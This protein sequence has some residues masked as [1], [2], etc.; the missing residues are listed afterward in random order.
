[1]LI[2][3][4]IIFLLI[5]WISAD[6]REKTQYVRLLDIFLYGPIMVY[7]SL[8]NSNNL[9]YL[10]RV[11]LLIIGSTTITYNAKNYLYN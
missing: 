3:L 5:G 1:M 11:C 7:I 8:D 9:R 10:F 4:L 2:I 6:S